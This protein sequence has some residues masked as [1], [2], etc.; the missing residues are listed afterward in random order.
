[1]DKRNSYASLSLSWLIKSEVQ[2]TL[3]KSFK[4][5]REEREENF[6]FP[7]SLF[8]GCGWPEMEKDNILLLSSQDETDEEG[9][10]VSTPWGSL[11]RY[12][13]DKKITPSV[14]LLILMCET[15]NLFFF[16]Q[17]LKTNPFLSLVMVPT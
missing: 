2:A 10:K 6:E 16:C 5:L 9:V 15:K 1:M 7:E 13:V 12:K 8:W 11:F 14:S 3:L 4:L 17:E